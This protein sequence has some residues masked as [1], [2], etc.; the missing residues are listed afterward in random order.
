L[1]EDC[2]IDGGINFRIVKRKA[3]A[4]KSWGE[5][6][7]V[8]P[9]SPV[10]LVRPLDLGMNRAGYPSPMDLTCYDWL[11][12][13]LPGTVAS[14]QG[15][16]PATGRFATCALFDPD[17]NGPQ[18]IGVDFPIRAFQGCLFHATGLGN[19]VYPACP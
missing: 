10:C 7:T 15:S 13:Q 6:S 5:V 17:G 2:D 1:F 12:A 4:V 16:D 11:E 9:R 18:P 3:R 19:A 8:W 14:I